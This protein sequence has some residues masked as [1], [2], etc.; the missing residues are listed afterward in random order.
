[1][2][3]PLLKTKLYIP[4]PYPGLVARQRLVEQLERGLQRKL[5]LVSAPAGFG[6][7]TL[8]SQWI[9]SSQRRVVWVSLDKGD[10]DTTRFLTYILAAVQQIDK[11]IG[12]AA[13]ELLHSPQPA[14]IEA[15]L[16]GL[17]NEIAEIPEPFF[18]VLDDYH[19]I[20]ERGVHDALVFI[21]D[22]LP[23]QMHLILS[24]RANPPWPLARLRARAEILELR[25]DDLRVTPEEAAIFLNETMGLGLRVEDVIALEV[26]TEGWIA[27]LQMAAISMQGREDQ[28]AFIKA[29]SGSHRFVLDY[30]VEEVLDQQS[31]SIQEFLLKTSILER[32]TASLC[33]A[34]TDRDN[35]Q[36]ILTQLDKANLFLV[37]L[38]DERCWYR[39]HHLFSDLLHNQ[40]ILIHPEEV[41]NLHR[42]ASQWFEEQ[43]FRDETIAHA[44]AARD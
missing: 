19:L 13:E 12:L 35:S 30:L 43:D 40:L 44:F 2:S 29:F 7:T 28:T 32:M 8:L 10:N 24:S 39:Y 26:R 37:P 14:N 31:P 20:T 16:T 36:S 9:A 34:V 4:P 22:N 21:L 6:K 15:I 33:D 42:R 27:G 17:I 23:P 1:M 3:T 5:T 18:L 25:A 41:P 38:D 11:N